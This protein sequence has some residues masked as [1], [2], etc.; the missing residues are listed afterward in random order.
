MN[1]N[2]NRWLQEKKRELG[3]RAAH[4]LLAMSANNDPFNKGTEGDFT[5]A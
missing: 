5:S 1:I 4:R 2:A 3:L